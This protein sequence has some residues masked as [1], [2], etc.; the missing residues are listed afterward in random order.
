MML[1][2]TLLLLATAQAAPTPVRSDPA[3]KVW[4]SD[5]RIQPGDWARAKV[6]LQ[7]DGYLL[8]FTTDVEGHVRVLFPVDPGDDA[9]VR[10]GRT[11]DLRGRGNRGSFLV[12]NS[13]GSGV[14]LAARTAEP[15]RFAGFVR[16]DHWDYGALDSA[17]RGPAAA[18][19][20]PDE[21]LLGL[22]QQM[23][24]GNQLDYDAATY[25]VGGG[26]VAYGDRPYIHPTYAS[27]WD[28]GYG[29]GYGYPTW[30]G[31]FD[32]WFCGPS[33]FSGFGFGLFF[34]P[35]VYSPYFYRPFIRRP[36]IVRGYPR[37]YG[38]FATTR[39]YVGKRYIP[40]PRP[41]QYRNRGRFVASGFGSF[42]GMRARPSFAPPRM[43]A[44]SSR[45]GRGGGGGGGR[46]H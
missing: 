3:V 20:N 1:P 23:A 38:G 45:G 44:P 19:S 11:V 33:F 32:P 21:V 42:G 9:F 30:Y 27:G 25:T 40:G 15:I 8:V 5:D 24:G 29:Y 28:Y 46:R 14:V 18:R 17:A 4:L 31:C 13:S 41:V 16:S 43:A 6:R 22:V 34:S 26:D 10:A 35:Y 36:V 7:D 2:F 12:G 39:G 37:V